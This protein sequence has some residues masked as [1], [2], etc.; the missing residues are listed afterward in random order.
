M[1]LAHMVIAIPL[2]IV[3]GEK[4]AKLYT[5]N[6][7]IIYESFSGNSLLDYNLCFMRLYLTATRHDQ[8]SWR[9]SHLY[10]I[11]FSR[12]SLV[13]ENLFTVPIM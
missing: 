6:T 2:K 8:P 13:S 5:V 9:S 1:L 11:G 12:S 7:N 3:V 4:K 10:N